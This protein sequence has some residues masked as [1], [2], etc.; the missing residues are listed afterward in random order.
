MNSRREIL[1][2]HYIKVVRKATT[3]VGLIA[4]V[5]TMFAAI[6]VAD[7]AQITSRSTTLSDSTPSSTTDN[8]AFSFTFGSAYTVKGIDIQ[9]CN[10]PVQSV[11][12]A[13]PTGGTL[14]AAATS[15][16]SPGAQCASFTYSSRTATDYK[17][18][19]ATGQAVTAASTCTFTIN[20]V[21]NPSSV[22]TQFY[23]RIIT[24]TDTAFSLPT[25]S[26]QDYGA[27]ADSTGTTLNVTA[28]VQES[29]VF[30]VGQTGACGSLSGTAVPIGG[31][32]AALSSSSASAAT[33]LMCVNTNAATGY[34]VQFLSN[35]S[36]GVGGAF[37][38]Y[39]GIAH[40]FS[41]N[42]AA[43]FF[44]TG[45]TGGSDFF[46]INVRNNVG[47]SGDVAS[48]ADYS[49][50]GAVAPTSYGAGYGTADKFAFAHAN[51]TT[52]VSETTG[53]TPNT[54]YTVSYEAQ[55]GTTTPTGQ[56]Q[57][58]MNYIATGTF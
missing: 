32:G 2:T 12:C 11:T 51:P 40:D 5:L 25:A 48:G 1:F 46:G 13:V 50:T 33:S 4:M 35:S 7:A 36:H 49:G 38:N 8:V 29:L 54:L 9:L 30:S 22:N 44:S 42:A 43:T 16:S 31:V 3:W 27:T 23:F 39:T 14:A 17:I 53:P 41:D 19:Y 21:T 18:T 34:T 57:V 24:Y 20:G 26:G 45:T 58:N 47:A 28:N 15:L 10:S 6:P 55:A 52:L 37:T 56:Y